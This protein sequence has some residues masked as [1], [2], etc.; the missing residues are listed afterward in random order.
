MSGTFLLISTFLASVV[1]SVE[2]LTII[3]ATGI[4]RGWR[5]ALMGMVAGLALLILLVVIFGPTIAQLI[6]LDALR[7]VIGTLLLIFGLQW[8][9]KA[10]LRASGLKAQRD[11]EAIFQREVKALDKSAV[12]DW[13][14]FVL[15]FKA[16]FLEGLEVVFIVVTF[17]A[18]AGNVPLAA[19]G[20]G[21]AVIVVAIAGVLLR[22]PL[23]RVPENGLKFAVGL[24][25]TA[26]GTFWSG[27]GIGVLWPGEDL[28]LLGLLA[29]YGLLAWLLVVALRRYDQRIPSPA[30]VAKEINS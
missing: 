26:F 14:S 23:S 1:E 16:V 15:C 9:R 29:G 25:L 22:H 2:A 3:L 27:E 13:T 8:L 28:M 17:G 11:E 6:P 30:P 21:L 7:V 20:A 19:L 18:S 5:S 10:I 12:T 4:T 24:L